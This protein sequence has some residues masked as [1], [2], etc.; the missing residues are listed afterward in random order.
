[1]SPI[2]W[3][4]QCVSLRMCLETGS[5][6][7]LPTPLPVRFPIASSSGGPPAHH[8]TP[9]SPLLSP[10]S[11]RCPVVSLTYSLPPRPA[12]EPS[13][14]PLEPHSLPIPLPSLSSLAP[15]LY[16]SS[17]Q[18]RS[19]SAHHLRSA[20]SLL[21]PTQPTA[22]PLSRPSPTAPRLD[23]TALESPPLPDPYTPYA[24]L[25]KLEIS[26]NATSLSPASR[27]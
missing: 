26:M 23:H 9:L 6:G 19:P 14:L 2:R 5:S 17:P 15:P 8:S 24:A 11:P 1:M 27:L 7:L 3:F 25:R 4:P 20:A 10:L 22:Q 18:P 16:P 12:R 13:A 21:S